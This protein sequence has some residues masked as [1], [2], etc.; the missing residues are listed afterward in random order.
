MTVEELYSAQQLLHQIMLKRAES[1]GYNL[2]DTE[3]IYDGVCDVTTYLSNSPRIMWIMKEPYDIIEAG[4]PKGGGWEVY[5]F[6][7]THPMWKILMRI[8]YG[9]RN[10]KYQI[11]IPDPDEEMLKLLKAT[12]YI[13]INKMPALTS[14]NDRQLAVSL[15]DWKDVVMEQV[16]VYNPDIIIFGNTFKQFEE[17]DFGENRSEDWIENASTPGPTEVFKT[18]M[19][20]V[21]INAYHPSQRNTVEKNRYIDT[22]IK[23]CIEGYY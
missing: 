18:K 6:T 7:L 19:G 22:I 1:L 13:N 4:T 20:K 8:T 14:S 10:K 3:P 23:A 9:I 16:K 5:N 12:A 2:E 17:G 11:D 21:L 15:R